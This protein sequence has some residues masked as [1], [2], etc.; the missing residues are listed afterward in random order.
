MSDNALK[1]NFARSLNKG[2]T[3]KALDEIRSR[4][5]K[6]LPCSVVS[7]KG[8]IVQVKFLVKSPFTLPNVTMPHFGPTYIRYPTQVGDMGVTV[9]ADA[10]I[11]GVS[12]LGGGTADI[13]TTGNLAAL[14]FVPLANKSW[15]DV[16]PDALLMHGKNGVVMRDTGGGVVWTQTP[17]QATLVIGST[18]FTF[19]SLGLFVTNGDVK[20]DLISLK[21]HK[22]TGVQSGGG[23]SGPAVP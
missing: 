9:S 15:F 20:A 21:L 13:S 7:K 5:G 1:Q 8:S 16:D 4:Q 3:D 11:G 10:Y 14:F 6:S 2:S 12:G 17:T 19:S 18:I 22:H 23:T